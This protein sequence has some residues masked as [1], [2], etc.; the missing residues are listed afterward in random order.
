M[1]EPPAGP[2]PLAGRR[3]AEVLATSTGGVGTHLRSVLPALADAGA[4]VTVCGPA[5]TDALFRF[6]AA[7][8]F[9]PVEIS[10]GLD[11]VADARAVPALRRATAG[12]DLVHAHG[13]RAGL[14]AAL[15]VRAVTRRA[16]RRP[17]VVTLHNALP[18]RSGPLRRL[19]AQAERATVRAA[20]VVLAAS[21]DLADN[22]RRLGARDVRT[23]PVSAPALPPARRGRDEVRAELGLPDG[24]PLVLAVGR[25]HPQKGYDVLLDAA[26]T[27]ATGPRPPLVAIA[28][29]GPLQADL[30]ARV[31]DRRLP[32]ALLGRRTDVADLLAAADLAV[33]PSRWEARSLTAQEALR[34]GTPLVATRTGG[35]P[36]LLGD[37]A[38]LVPPGDAAALARAVDALLADPARAAALAA[39]GRER[40]AGWPDE[41]ATARALVALYRELLGPPGTPAP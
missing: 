37:A 31:R 38:E 41:A 36:E 40:A 24:R 12:A 32:V 25:L 5:A 21:G 2:A 3:L 35:L 15:A 6:A 20:D 30:A 7:A 8:A 34:T 28:G 23:A 33:L 26:E 1:A 10:A 19:L 29:D 22:A 4:A 11:P 16:P 14:V 9:R 27:W 39:A 17:L 18:E 13:L